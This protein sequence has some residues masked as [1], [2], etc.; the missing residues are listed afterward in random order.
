MKKKFLHHPI[1]NNSVF[2]LGQGEGEY[3]STFKFTV[4][5][6]PHNIFNLLRPTLHRSSK[7]SLHPEKISKGLIKFLHL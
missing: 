5:E 4:S 1:K 6:Q 2:L 3:F 7:Q